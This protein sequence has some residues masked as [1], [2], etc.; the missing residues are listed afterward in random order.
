[1]ELIHGIARNVRASADADALSLVID[2]RDV[3][4]QELGAPAAEDDPEKAEES[5]EDSQVPGH[6]EP[7]HQEPGN[8]SIVKD[9]D[10]MIVAGRTDD[11]VFVG[12]A[13]WNVTQGREWRASVKADGFQGALTL[14]LSGGALWAGLL[15]DSEVPLWLWSER[16]VCFAL[17]LLFVVFAIVY[18]A[19][20]VEKFLA[21]F[22]V[23]RA[24]LESLKGTASNVRLSTDHTGAF[25][26]IGGRPIELYMPHKIVIADGDEV[27]VTGQRNGAALA[28]MGYRNETRGIVGRRRIVLS[29]AWRLLLIGALPALV[30]FGLWFG[31]GDTAWVVAFRRALAMVFMM[32]IVVLALDRLFGWLLEL[33]AWRRVKAGP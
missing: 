16:I 27:V 29:L 2:G 20:M 8:R 10:E 31:D 18:V 21:R 11:G 25:L 30:I 5:S 33:E 6:Q 13:F 15:A 22:M 32:A 7:A 1:M 19:V 3:R 24:A 4:L 26:D 9:G 28:G 17:A 12:Q 14:I 23:S